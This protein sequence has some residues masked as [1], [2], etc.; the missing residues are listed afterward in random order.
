MVPCNLHTA[1]L[2]LINGES[3]RQIDLM[4]Q[5]CFGIMAGL[6]FETQHANKPT[7][8]WR[9]MWVRRGR[10][11]RPQEGLKRDLWFCLRR[12]MCRCSFSSLDL[13][14]RLCSNR[15]PLYRVLSSLQ[16]NRELQPSNNSIIEYSELLCL[17]YF[18]DI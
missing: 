2:R 5:N 1:F 13:M 15:H 4:I 11:V 18:Y 9:N 6:I 8:K 16:V 10:Q 12:V 3:M 7:R 17:L 14:N